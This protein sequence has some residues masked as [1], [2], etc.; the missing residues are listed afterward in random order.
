M[1][2]RSLL[3]QEAAH[4]AGYGLNPDAYPDA[5][6]MIFSA[7]ECFLREGEPLTWLY[8]VLSGKAKSFRSVSNGKQLLI[9]FFS[10][11]GMIGE[12]E[13]MTSPKAA[14]ATMQAI[15]EFTC[16]ALP[17]RTYCIQLKENI[18]FMNC[19]AKE[20]AQKLIQSD[21]NSSITILNS[22]RERLCAYIYQTAQHDVFH[23]V[24]TDVASQLG[25][26]YRHLLRC[27]NALC[28]EGILKKEKSG[29][30]ILDEVL[31]REISADFYLPQFPIASAE[32]GIQ[33]DAAPGEGRRRQRGKHIDLL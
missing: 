4:L 9:S 20:L 17:L 30:R 14:L 5:V 12:V 6:L 1:I 28:T 21:T 32:L 19:V 8:F 10:S 18:L 33:K 29:Y 3:P 7:G 23:E 31:L 2:K 11:S 13:L 15:T 26:S 27:L 16:I 25:T 24:L 22:V